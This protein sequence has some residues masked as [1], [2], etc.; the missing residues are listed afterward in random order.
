MRSARGDELITVAEAA[1]RLGISEPTVRR[2][3]RAG[4]LRG[5]RVGRDWQVE[6]DPDQFST[7]R[8]R[9]RATRGL[10]RAEVSQALTFLS[11]TDSNELWIPDALRWQD[12]I[13]A[14]EEL[15]GRVIDRV[16]RSA[17]DP[18]EFLAVPKS[19]VATRHA[20]LLRL[21]DRVA[22][23][24]TV[25]RLSDRIDNATSDRVFSARLAHDD[26]YFLRRSS[27]LYVKWLSAVSE[28]LVDPGQCLLAT[29]LV[30]YFD[31]IDQTIL[32]R[33]LSDVAGDD[34]VLGALRTQL[35]RWSIV[36]N[37]GIPQGPNA[38]RVLGNFYLLP[39]DRAMISAGFNYWRYM[40][41]IRVVAKDPAEGK[42]ASLLL[43][44][45]CR[46]RG[47]VLSASKTK[48]LSHEEAQAAVANTEKSDVDYLLNDR[49]E[50]QAR[51]AL[52]RMLRGA[53]PRSGAIN[54]SDAK[55]ALWRLARL[56][57][58]SAVN[59]IMTRLGSLA[60]VA[61]S[62]SA[63]I[64]RFIARNSTRV[65][66]SKYLNDPASNTSEY[67]ECWLFAT[68]L[69]VHGPLDPGWL[70]RARVVAL[71]RNNATHR[72]VLA[73]GVI[74]LGGRT[75]DVQYVKQQ[76]AQDHNPEI[77]RGAIIALA[78]AGRFDSAVV[79]QVVGRH[80]E[81]VCT[82]NYLRSRQKFPSLVYRGRTVRVR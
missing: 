55:F 8:P 77:A 38:S 15:I 50:D 11:N 60:P 58:S 45:L 16:T 73:L 34:Q 17:Y 20:T 13:D 42:R 18:P 68:M 24:A 19:E 44:E 78:R 81:L 70:D 40:D 79:S 37:R 10:T 39:V 35:A 66:I 47:L 21:E 64:L 53:V 63:Y 31:T 82:T 12:W 56:L 43:E 48:L 25:G 61:S 2:R 67:L 74:T 65:A 59:R 5:R 1:S 76:A 80:P 46:A 29:D 71:D 51:N 6:L 75:A 52:R 4:E 28:Q 49:R 22:Y 3:L 33:E 27:G 9:K 41:D 7:V 32:L 26:K 69:E 72:R 30:S 54:P 36:S 14:K 23:Q 57:D 62:V